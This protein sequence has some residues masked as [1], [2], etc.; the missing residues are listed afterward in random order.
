MEVSYVDSHCDGSRKMLWSH[1]KQGRSILG[2][3]EFII[4]YEVLNMV[5]SMCTRDITDKSKWWLPTTF[6][7]DIWGLLTD[8]PK[9]FRKSGRP[10]ASAPDRI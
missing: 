6:S 9:S 3:Y 8:A 4:T 1:P 2:S 10:P 5:V 7:T